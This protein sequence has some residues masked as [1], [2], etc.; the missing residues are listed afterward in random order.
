MCY[1]ILYFTPS[2]EKYDSLVVLKNLN[3]EGSLGSY[4]CNITLPTLLTT[5]SFL[6]GLNNKT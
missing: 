2:T 6:E 3:P 4:L 1:S 5:V